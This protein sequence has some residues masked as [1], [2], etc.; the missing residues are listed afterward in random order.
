MLWMNNSPNTSALSGHVAYFHKF[1]TDR[2]LAVSR[3]EFFFF[4]FFLYLV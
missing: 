2:L 4:L 3:K 1:L